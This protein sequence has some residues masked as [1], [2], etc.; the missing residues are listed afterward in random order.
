MM[1]EDEAPE[2]IGWNAIDQALSAVYGDVEPKHWG[3][4]IPFFLGGKDP[5]TGLSAY[6][7]VQDE[8]V[9]HFVTYGF[10]ELYEKEWKDP[11]V[12]GFGF[13]MTFRLVTDDVEKDAT[14]VFNFLQNL[15]RYV[16]ETGRVFGEGHTMSLNGPIQ[17]ESD[18][19]I[20]AITFILD[21]QL[22]R[23]HTPNGSVEFLQI[24]GLTED[25]LQ[26]VQYWNSRSFV[27]LISERNPMLVTDLRR[28]SLL[29]DDAF[30]DTVAKRTAEE[31]ASSGDFFTDLF[32]FKISRWTRTCTLKLG[33]LVVDDLTRRLCGRI[34]FGRNFVV[35]GQLAAVVF[36]ASDK[37]EW[38]TEEDTLKL[39]LTSAT[40][41]A[42]RALLLPQAGSYKIPGLERFVI[43]VERTEIKDNEGK[44]TKVIG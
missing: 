30:A 38:S 2:A 33:A 11:E 35:S 40:A 10:S 44:V 8:K 21:P 17:V 43:E 42:L 15:A 31:G 13:E 6:Q 36:I 9:W 41:H 34:P 39:E 4:V 12:S 27:G 37:S 24:F 18:T 26:A 22:G 25:E 20:D 1:A 5:L 16:F 29:D 28:N 7:D 23:I 32:S 19:K 3:T 14:W